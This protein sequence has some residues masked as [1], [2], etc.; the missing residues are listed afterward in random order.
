MSG[1][2]YAYD[3][4]A[5]QEP[6]PLPDS[7]QVKS[8][9]YNSVSQHCEPQNAAQNIRNGNS[10]NPERNTATAQNPLDTF[11]Q[12]ND[13]QNESAQTER[14][15]Y[16]SPIARGSGSP[17]KCP[18]MSTSKH[19]VGTQQSEHSHTTCNLAGSWTVAIPCKIPAGGSNYRLIAHESV[20]LHAE[21]GNVL[22][23]ARPGAIAQ[24]P[25]QTNKTVKGVQIVLQ[26]ITFQPRIAPIDEL[27]K[28]NDNPTGRAD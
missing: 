16:G 22:V 24:A 9:N 27:P 21:Q 8:E 6:A 18:K 13:E 15:Y 20:A 2:N 1:G 25:L 19:S 26:P 10:R 5:P 17:Q 11:S 7:Q 14:G 12:K 28:D 23:F 4:D 3:S